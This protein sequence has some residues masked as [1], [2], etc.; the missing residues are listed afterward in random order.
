GHFK[1]IDPHLATGHARSKRQANNLNPM[2]QT[3]IA[4]TLAFVSVLR[5]GTTAENWPQF[6]GPNCSGVAHDAKPPQKIGPSNSVLWRIDVP[7]SP[8]SPCVW[9]DRIFLTTFADNQLETVCYSRPNGQLLWARSIRP[10]RLEAFHPTDG[11][12]A[13]STPATDGRK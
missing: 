4:L 10:D 1:L 12:P 5:V 7:W 3:R 11:S 9:R 6:R 2:R 8:S 13:A